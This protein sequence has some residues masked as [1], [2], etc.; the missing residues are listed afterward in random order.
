MQPF[1]YRIAGNFRGENCVKISFDLLPALHCMCFSEPRL[2]VFVGQNFVEVSL[3]TTNI[4]TT[5][6]TRY[7]VLYTYNVHR[8]RLVHSKVLQPLTCANS[9]STWWNAS[10]FKCLSWR[11]WCFK[12]L[13]TFELRTLTAVTCFIA[14]FF[15]SV[16]VFNSF[17]LAS[18]SCFY[19]NNGWLHN[20]K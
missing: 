5:K 9:S 6:I 10:L 14:T 7:T 13:V 4:Y 11:R 8:M 15:S 1:S 16:V 3:P 2:L 20:D 19:D 17:S 18:S 12:S